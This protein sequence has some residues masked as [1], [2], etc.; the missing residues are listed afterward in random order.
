MADLAGGRYPQYNPWLAMLGLTNATQSDIPARSNLEY[1]GLSTVTNGALAASGVIAAVPVAVDQGTVVSAVTILVGGTAASTPTHQ[2]AALYQGT[3]T[4]PVLMAQST[5]ATTAAVAASAPY[6][7]TLATPQL[8]TSV[9]APNGFI[10]VAV[11]FTGTTVP[12]AAGTSV[13]TAV[14][15]QWFTSTTTPK[16]AAPLGFS[17]TS[18]SSVAGTATATL[19]SPSAAAVA[20]IVIL[21]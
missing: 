21:T 5:D 8:I 9:N 1:L 18:G 7:F 14:G 10:Y 16:G 12:T 4:T 15:Y 20:P 19:A 6:Q 13:P 2:F 17:V 3:G 11:S